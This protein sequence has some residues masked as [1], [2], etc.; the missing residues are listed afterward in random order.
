MCGI[1]AI[2]SVAITDIDARAEEK[3]KSELLMMLEKIRHRGEPERFGESWFAPGVALGTN[4]LAIVDPDHGRQPSVDLHGRIAVICNGEIYGFAKLRDQ[5]RDHGYVFHSAT[6]TEVLVAAYLVWGQ[7]MLNRIDGIFAFVLYDTQKHEFLAARDHFGVKPLYYTVRDEIYR[8]ASEKKSL[9]GQGAEIC[10]VLPGTYVSN[11][12]VDR[13]Y[14]LPQNTS[15][16]STAEAVSTYRKLFENAVREQV[17]TDLPV[18]VMFSGGIDSG[19][20]L[21]TALRF[22]RN[23]TALTVGSQ[24]SPDVEIA[25]RYCSE[26]NIP[27]FVEYLDEEALIQSLPEVVRG[28]E[29]F[30]PINVM[31]SAISFFLF[32]LAKRRGFKIALTGEGSDEVLA[33]YDLFKTHENPVELM[34]YRVGNLYQADLQRVDRASM[35]NTVEARV[36]YLDRKLL[37]FC[38][39]LPMEFKL[40]G[41]VEKWVL[42]EAFRDSL[43][44]YIADRPK[45]RMPDG[46][47]LKGSLAEH[48]RSPVRFDEAIVESL[49]IDSAEGIFFLNMYV[50]A[51]YPIPRRRTKRAGFDYSYEGSFIR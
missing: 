2:I 10:E 25:E 51:G 29:F 28:S 39:A 13:Y 22:N 3:R 33:G 50:E 9:V 37:E 4:R 5:L 23:V 35:M 43:P 34:K 38:Y 42:R 24:G 47:G 36:P 18:A 6:D 32:S 44:E 1:S 48:A 26:N 20:L 49:G 31:E 45:A 12:G 30:E 8:F 41:G 19:A 11:Q 14:E 46:A 7:E 27:H 40:R 17:N 15:D 21:Q 16:I